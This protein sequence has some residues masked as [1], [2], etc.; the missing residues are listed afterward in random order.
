MQAQ[1]PGDFRREGDE[2]F[3]DADAL[4]T[5]F[6]WI[7]GYRVVFHQLPHNW[8]AYSPDLDGVV[9]TG[10]TRHEVERNMREALRLHLTALADDRRA[11]PWL[12]ER[13]P[14]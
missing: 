1:V 7:D 12:Y 3:V 4:A 2:D 13:S 8:D 5:E 10:S 9:T 6:G 14:S 11:R